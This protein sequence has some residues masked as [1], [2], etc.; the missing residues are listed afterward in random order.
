M[1]SAKM[2]ILIFEHAVRVETRKLHVEMARAQK[3]PSQFL[4]LQSQLM[5]N[6]WRS[7]RG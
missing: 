2:G 6:R 4:P 3:R 7:R 1:I 5:E